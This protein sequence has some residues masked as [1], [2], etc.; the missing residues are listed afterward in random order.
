MPAAGITDEC[1][2]VRLRVERLKTRERHWVRRQPA[3]RV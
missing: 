3:E 2:S 1:A